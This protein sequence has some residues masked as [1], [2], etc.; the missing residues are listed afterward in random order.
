MK[1]FII[2]C[3]LGIFLN[4]FAFR[5]VKCDYEWCYGI[6]DDGTVE[7][8]RL[9]DGFTHFDPADE[10]Y[11]PLLDII[12]SVNNHKPHV[13]NFSPQEAEAIKFERELRSRDRS[14]WKFSNSQREKLRWLRRED[15][16][17]ED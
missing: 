8:W 9:A 7:I 4:T 14:R 2:L 12:E 6:Y 16:M 5:Q 3:S 13:W 1:Y 15:P 11:R 10:R 17:E